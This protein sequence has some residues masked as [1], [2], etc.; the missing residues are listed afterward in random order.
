[1]KGLFVA[2]RSARKTPI[3]IEQRLAVRLRA[4]GLATTAPLV[5]G[6]SGGADSLALAAALARVREPGR[7]VVLA[8]VDHGLRPDSADHAAGAERLA[9]TLELPFHRVAMEKRPD[10]IHPGLGVEEAARRER[11]RL[12]AGVAGDERAGTLVLAHHRDDQAETVLLHL[13]RGAGTTGIAGMAELSIRRI[14]WWDEPGQ[15]SESLTVWRPMLA[16]PRAELAAYVAARG[17][18]PMHDPT[19]DDRAYRRNLVRHE[20]LPVLERAWPGAAAALVRHGALA[21][22]DDALLSRIAAAALAGARQ[23]AGLECGRVAAEE[24]AIRRRLVRAWVASEAP[25]LEVSA[26]RTEALLR[27][28]EPGRGGRR[29]DIGQGWTATARSGIVRLERSTGGEDG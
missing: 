9:A 28:F 24:L 19:N 15:P 21:A 6:F 25:G 18:A 27:L 26:E 29:I 11:Y 12:L 2:P 7:R 13:L 23:G 10:E 14:P 22:E 5:V 1:M 4:S 3:G 8:H 17:L 20:L 16:E